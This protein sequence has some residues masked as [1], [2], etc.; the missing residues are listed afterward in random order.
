M[1]FCLYL[2]MPD[3]WIRTVTERI[4]RSHMHKCWNSVQGGVVELCIFIFPALE[5][6]DSNRHHPSNNVIGVHHDEY[7]YCDWKS[8]HPLCDDGGVVGWRRWSFCC[9][10]NASQALDECHWT[11]ELLPLLL[12]PQN[13]LCDHS[14]LQSNRKQNQT[15]LELWSIAIRCAFNLTAIIGRRLWDAHFCVCVMTH[16]AAAAANAANCIGKLS[17]NHCLYKNHDHY[18]NVR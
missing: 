10:W 3:L 14:R 18:D 6:V 13:Q 11:T 4:G 9:H 7:A 15:S 2:E 8:V 17:L 12:P 1:C 5:N 16:P